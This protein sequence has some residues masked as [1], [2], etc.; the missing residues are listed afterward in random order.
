MAQR[1]I[2]DGAAILSE[3]AFYDALVQGLAGMP[4]HFGRNLDALWDALTRDV[5][6]PFAIEW[7]DAARSA[8]AIGPR[9]A[10]IVDVLR[11][12]ASARDDFTLV[13]A[14]E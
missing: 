3:D 12:A 1:C 5:P 10:R 2:L 14:G 6:G 7:R 13:I 8:R 4:V 9:Y 11:E